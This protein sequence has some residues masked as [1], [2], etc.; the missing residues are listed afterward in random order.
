MADETQVT[1]VA[2]V[3]NA[4]QNAEVDTSVKA[5]EA[6][7]KKNFPTL[8]GYLYMSDPDNTNP[9]WHHYVMPVFDEK[10]YENLPW[11]VYKERPSDDLVDPLY[12]VQK[13]GW[14]ENAHDAQTQILAEAQAEIDTLKNNKAEL[15]ADIQAIQ[16]AQTA[17]SAQS[18]TIT[19]KVGQM[20]QMMSVMQTTLQN[21]ATGSGTQPTQPAGTAQTTANV[22]QTTNN[23]QT[24][25]AT[26][27]GGNK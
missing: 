23:A 10:A 22:A 13:G 3:E 25:E 18:Q 12:S 9:L 1:P 16:Q 15:E 2:G 8:I 27:Q 4:T 21:L 5:Q 19:Q 26:Q 11:H 20:V 14:I 7:L 24:T 6:S 17:N